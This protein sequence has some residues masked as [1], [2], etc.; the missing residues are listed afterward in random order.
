MPIHWIVSKK[1]TM[2]STL[3]A[4]FRKT[5]GHVLCAGRMQIAHVQ[6]M[7]IEA[8]KAPWRRACPVGEAEVRWTRRRRRPGPNVLQQEPPERGGAWSLESKLSPRTG[9]WY[10]GAALDSDRAVRAKPFARIHRRR[11]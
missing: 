8:A 7:H 6:F 3:S 5:V 2:R 10:V 4:L 1:G 9:P 11:K